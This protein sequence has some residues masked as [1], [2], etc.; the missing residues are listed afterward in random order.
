MRRFLRP[1]GRGPLAIS[2]FIAIPLFFSSL[3]AASLALEKPEKFEWRAART[4]C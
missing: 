1:Q 4:A 2:A 3:M